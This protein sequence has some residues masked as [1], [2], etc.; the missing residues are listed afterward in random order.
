LENLYHVFIRDHKI[1][2]VKVEIRRSF[3]PYATG[4]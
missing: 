4:I 2:S 3:I 1:V